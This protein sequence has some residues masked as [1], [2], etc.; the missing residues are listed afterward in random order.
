MIGIVGY[1]FVGQALGSVLLTKYHIVDPQHSEGVSLEELLLN[2][3]KAIFLCLPTPSN[4]DGCDDTLV[5]EYVK[6]LADYPGLLV[7]KSTVPPS[8]VSKILEM[9][10]TTVFWPELLRAQNAASD[11][12]HPSLV[13]IGANRTEI[14]DELK[15]LIMEDTKIEIKATLIRHVTPIEAVIFKYT[16]NTFLA[17][18]VAFMHQ[19]Y[20]WLRSQGVE[21]SWN[22]VTELLSLE[23]RV[24][25]SHLQVP[26]VD[27]FGFGGMCFPKDTYALS[28]DANGHLTLLEAVI[29]ENKKL[30]ERR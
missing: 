25:S 8:T 6:L 17:T 16:T 9:R 4:D 26:G 30:R 1:G 19:M 20:L 23:G 12:Q 21:E 5:L 29:E 14:Y 11:M 10:A 7:V 28:K 18:K 3:P 22:Q 15:Q 24:G 2:N 27:G 13:V